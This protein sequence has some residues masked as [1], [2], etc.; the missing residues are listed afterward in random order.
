MQE[1]TLNVCSNYGRLN[2]NY[3]IGQAKSWGGIQ[4]IEETCNWS[5]IEQNKRNN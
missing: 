1:A 2:F 5:K 3:E 4:N